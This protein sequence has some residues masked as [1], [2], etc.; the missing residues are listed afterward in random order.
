[1][2]QANQIYAKW[3]RLL[4]SPDNPNELYLVIEKDKPMSIET[5][6]SFEERYQEE[7]V[8]LT[9]TKLVRKKKKR[10]KHGKRE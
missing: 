10:K 8:I 9:I 4:P 1:M 7:D 2:G 5:I 3:K 6:K